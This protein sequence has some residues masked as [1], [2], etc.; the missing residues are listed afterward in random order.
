MFELLK[1]YFGYDSLRPAQEPI[2]Q[3]LLQGKDTLAIMPTGGGKSLCYQL[4]ALM[5][6]GLTVV[7]CPLI[8]LMHDQVTALK[9][10]GIW[11]EYINSSQELEVQNE[12]MKNLNSLRNES[13]LL[14]HEQ[15]KLLYISPEKLLA[16][17]GYFLNYL[18]RKSVV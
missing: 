9:E 15:I 5:Q 11:A 1:K 12:I 14:P 16:N 3:S 4:P 2:I 7:V 10:N 6:A 8:A 13:N 17:D 18:D